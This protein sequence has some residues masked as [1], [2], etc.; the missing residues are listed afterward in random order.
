MFQDL[1]RQ[2]LSGF[3]NEFESGSPGS[4][5]ENVKASLYVSSKKFKSHPRHN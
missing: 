3:G 2:K 5:A 1:L 4:I